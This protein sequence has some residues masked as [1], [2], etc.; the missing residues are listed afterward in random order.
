[1]AERCE[2]DPCI[3]K[4]RDLIVLFKDIFSMESRYKK[5]ISLGKELPP[6]NP[7]ARTSANLVA[8][9]QSNFYLEVIYRD[10]RIFFNGDSDA[11]ISK[12]L[13]A[14]LIRVYS[15]EYP[16]TI[17]FCPPSYLKEL[18]IQN[19]LSIGRAQGLSSLYSRMQKEAFKCLS[20]TPSLSS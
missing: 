17:A 14:L 3:Q 7:D 18:G 11:L 8:G 16:E 10:S 4:Q 1:M 19:Q 2:W 9:C 15:E 12:G 5:I 13:A 20:A 6:F